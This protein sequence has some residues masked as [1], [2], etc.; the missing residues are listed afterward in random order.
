VPAKGEDHYWRGGSGEALEDRKQGD[1]AV[2]ASGTRDPRALQIVE[3][4]YAL[5]GEAGLEGLTIRGILSR[6]GLARRAFYERFTGKD[7]LMLAVFEHAIRAAAAHFDGEVKRLAYPLD[8]LRLIVHAIALGSDANQA[9]GPDFRDRRS[10]AL[11]REHLRLAET[12]PAALQAALGPLLDLI[13]RLLAEG[14]AAGII[15][16]ASPERLAPLIYNLV[17]TTVHTEFL[18]QGGSDRR[19]RERL[20]EDVWRFCLGG[21]LAD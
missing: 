11:S 15:P 19:E 20:A 13:A 18:Q 10:T 17:A 7:D 5:L 6:T 2:A 14:M 3:A 21:I 4:A 9:T 1:A 12:Q 16:R 8:R